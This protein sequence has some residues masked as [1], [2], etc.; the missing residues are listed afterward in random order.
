MPY[1]LDLRKRVIEFI[2]KGGSV[3][4][5]AKNYQVSRAT[6]YRWQGR[7]DLKPTQVTRRKR[8]LDWDA[9]RKDIEQNPDT[10]LSDRAKNFGVRTNAIWY[11]IKEM[12]ITRKKRS[13]IQRK[14]Q[15]RADRILQKAKGADKKVWK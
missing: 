9:V 1:S 7:E 3:S 13:Q 2:E 10:K 6:I 14:K 12:K 11:A 5:A 8:K 4:K 15:R